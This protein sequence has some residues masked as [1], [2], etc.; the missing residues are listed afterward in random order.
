M[1]PNH[2]EDFLAL[3]KLMCATSKVNLGQIVGFNKAVERL[4]CFERV[5]MAY[6]Q[7]R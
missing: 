4:I 5:S 1:W 3:L 6:S 7:R 2:I